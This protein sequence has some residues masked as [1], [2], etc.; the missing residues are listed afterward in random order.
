MPGIFYC[1][2]TKAKGDTAVRPRVEWDPSWDDDWQSAQ[3]KLEEEIEEDRPRN[4][5]DAVDLYRYGFAV[6]RRHP[7]RE[8]SDVESELYQDYETGMSE[9]GA[10]SGDT[11]TE[12]RSWA[13]RGWEAARER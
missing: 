11:W 2:E 4:P 3:A 9:P 12:R 7:S 13:E 6:A 8:W 10:L 1:T 5:K